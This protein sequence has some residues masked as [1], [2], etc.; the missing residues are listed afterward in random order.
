MG[1]VDENA[2]CLS[3]D[4]ILISIISPTEEMERYYINSVNLVVDR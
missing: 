2:E 1:K 4:V 3:L